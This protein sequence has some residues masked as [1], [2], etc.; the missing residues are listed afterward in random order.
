MSQLD[1]KISKANAEAKMVCRNSALEHMAELERLRIEA[2][3]NNTHSMH[4]NWE[5]LYAKRR[6]SKI[7][8]VLLRVLQ[9]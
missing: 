6:A 8:K 9:Q 5:A 3:A 7:S 4:G 2:E 1:E